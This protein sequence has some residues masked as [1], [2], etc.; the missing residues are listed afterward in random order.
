LRIFSI[1]FLLGSSHT[2]WFTG[3]PACDETSVGL[4]VV[5]WKPL[6]SSGGS[7]NSMLRFLT[8]SLPKTA[9]ALGCMI[10]RF[11]RLECLKYSSLF[12]RDRSMSL[13]FHSSMYWKTLES[14][15]SLVSFE[16]SIRDFTAT[17]D[18]LTRIFTFFATIEENRLQAKRR[19]QTL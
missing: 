12:L 10:E 14:L 4:P 18:N 8:T 5:S 16:G 17:Y 19:G 11:P 3:F 15:F 2:S 6:G 9:S 7:Q 13:D 1:S